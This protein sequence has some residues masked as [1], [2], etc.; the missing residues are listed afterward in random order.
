MKG[1][2]YAETPQVSGDWAQIMFTYSGYCDGFADDAFL[3]ED[4]VRLHTAA[5]TPHS[6]HTPFARHLRGLHTRGGV[7]AILSV[8]LAHRT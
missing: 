7:Q 1:N 6:S 8:L 4:A 5:L 2:P 3:K